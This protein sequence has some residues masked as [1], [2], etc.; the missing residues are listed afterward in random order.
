[1]S[2]QES[3]NAI[4]NRLL[5]LTKAIDQENE[6]ARLQCGALGGALVGGWS[7]A[8]S[9]EFGYSPLVGASVLTIGVMAGLAA[10]IML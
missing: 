6:A 10:Q 1:M 5:E 4:D 7:I 2:L 8:A 9:I 3:K